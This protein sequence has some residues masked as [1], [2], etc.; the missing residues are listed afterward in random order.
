[1]L[2]LEG[3]VVDLESLVDL[4]LEGKPLGVAVGLR[5]DEDV[6]GQGREAR[7]DLPDVQVV[8]LD[9][10]GHG[11]HR[12]AD[13][14][15]VEAARCRL[16]EHPARLPEQAVGGVE[17]DR[18]DDQRRDPVR[19]V[20]AGGQDHEPGDRREDERGE[21]G[22]Q[23]LEGALDVERLPVGL[24]ERPGR[25]QVDDDPEDRDGEDDPALDDRRIDQA[26]DALVDDQQS[27]HE[28][29]GAVE[30][31]AEDAGALPA[32][33][34]RALGGPGGEPDRDEGEDESG[35]VG[36]HVGRVGEQ[37]QR[38]G[39]DADDDLDG[40]EAD[41]QREGDRQLRAVGVGGDAV[42]MAGVSAVVVCRGPS[43]EATRRIRGSAVE[44]EMPGRRRRSVL[45]HVS[46]RGR[47]RGLSVRPLGGAAA[48]SLDA[49]TGVD[50]LLLAGVERM[51][52]GADLDVDLRLG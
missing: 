12:V 17:H 38:V 40:H 33:G 37:R 25:D 49:A 15:G 30:L 22:E 6:R 50:Q 27:E 52:G 48:E 46:R 47:R 19:L 35:G 29:R 10:P 7:S 21:V 2:D 44:A 16:E 41:D 23:M 42:R 18:G 45:Q 36:E 14:V 34:Q 4:V 39:E 28:Q 1:M 11:D 26:P 51:A 3:R 32:E 20:E 43:I 5:L 9:H 13:L 24:R 31:G 8:H